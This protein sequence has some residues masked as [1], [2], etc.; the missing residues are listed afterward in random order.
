MDPVPARDWCDVR[1]RRLRF[2]ISG[3]ESFFQIHRHFWF[4]FFSCGGDLNRDN[5]A[6]LCAGRFRELPV[7]FKPVA[8]P[9]VW[10]EHR[11]KMATVDAAFNCRHA[12][13]GELCA[14][15]V[16]Q[17]Q[18][19]PGTAL[20]GLGWPQEFRFEP[21]FRGSFGHLPERMQL[22]SRIEPSFHVAVCSFD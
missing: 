6:G 21:N 15:L 22:G 19:Y 13:R 9:P 11:F 4:W 3:R 18:K 16:R 7:H 8:L 14:A 5:V 20:L 1:P 17:H 2:N 10:L 12:A